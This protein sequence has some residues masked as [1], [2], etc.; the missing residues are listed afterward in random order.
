MA[1]ADCERAVASYRRDK[2]HEVMAGLGNAL[3]YD[4]RKLQAR[5]R[6]RLDF[7][8]QGWERQQE[9]AATR[10]APLFQINADTGRDGRGRVISSTSVA[11]AKEPIPWSSLA[12]TAYKRARVD[13]LRLAISAAAGTDSPSPSNV[14]D[15]LIAV[16]TPEE[17]AE[18]S[19]RVVAEKEE[20]ESKEA[21][22]AAWMQIGHKLCDVL[23]S[24]GNCRFTFPAMAVC[25]AL[26]QCGWANL[27][28][29]RD[30]LGIG[31]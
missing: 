11:V 22:W 14:I 18:L 26:R 1:R 15:V 10:R 12:R 30:K 6:I 29:I 7:K 4:E 25:V 27:R 9:Y 21:P 31:A 5:E 13:K 2:W 16:L 24:V 20:K 8:A 17:E 19:R 3:G 23:L 28:A